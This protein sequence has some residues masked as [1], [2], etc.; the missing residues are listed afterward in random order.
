MRKQVCIVIK[1][2]TYNAYCHHRTV[3]V[4][5]MQQNEI[6][7]HVI[8]IVDLRVDHKYHFNLRTRLVGYAREV[9]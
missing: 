8:K 5:G 1:L 4:M 6:D 7:L 3:N 2:F 9:V